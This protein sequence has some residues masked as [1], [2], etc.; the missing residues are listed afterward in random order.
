MHYRCDREYIEMVKNPPHG[1]GKHLNPCIDCKIFFIRKAAEYMIE[2]EADFIA[3]GEVVGQRPMSQLKHTMNHI[4][5]ETG[6]QDR[7]L[8]PLSAK[9][10]KP[11]R[12]E[13]E[14]LIDR[15][16]LLDISGRGRR[17]QMELAE[18]YGIKE[19]SSPAGGC[20]FTDANIARRVNDMFSH[21]E[22]TSPLDLY[23]TTIGRHFRISEGTKIIISRNEKENIELEK[24]VTDSD[25]YM[26]PDFRGPAA[27]LRGT[28][29]EEDIFTAASIISRY[30]K[31]SEDE[32]TVFI[33][34]YSDK[35]S[36][37]APEAIEDS[38]LETLRI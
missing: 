33:K 14:G 2:T 36:I 5:K 26:E 8:R 31:P 13:E 30:G 28:P 11:T 27:F 21:L 37:K 20:L 22:T 10:L 29:S 16:R 17:R 19:Y 3:T 23:L 12:M 6:L 18:K 7:L 38:L 25:L 15:E 9:L 24:Y 34:N 4:L 35:K 1:Y 32:N